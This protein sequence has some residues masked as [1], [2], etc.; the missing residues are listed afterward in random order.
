MSNDSRAKQDSPAQDSN[1]SYSE[2]SHNHTRRVTFTKKQQIIREELIELCNDEINKGMKGIQKSLQGLMMKQND[3]LETVVRSNVT[4]TTI[5]TTPIRMGSSRNPR[6]IPS[7][8]Q[9]STAFASGSQN[10]SNYT[11]FQ[12]S[13]TLTF[14]FEGS[15]YEL[16]D[17]AYSK[18]SSES[19]KVN[20]KT[21]LIYY[22]EEMQSEAITYN[23]FMQPF[24]MLKPWVKYA[25]NT[26]PPTCILSDL[27]LHDN[28]IE[29]YNRMKN[30]L[31]A[32]I[33]KST[34]ND[35][36]YKAIIKHRSIGKDGFEVLYELMTLCHPKLMVATSKVRDT[37]PR[38]SLQ[39]DESIYEY[40][41]RLTTW[42]TIEEINGLEHNDD[43]V[44]NIMMEQMR[45]DTKYNLA[46][47]SI[48]SELTLKDTLFRTTGVAQ[49]PE[50]LKLYH[51]PST[52]LSYYSKDERIQLFP[53]DTSTEAS[54]TAI[55]NQ[56]SMVGPTSTQNETIRDFAQ[57]IVK[58]TSDP[59]TA[60]A[61]VARE[62][63]DEMCE[64][65]GLFGHNIYKSGCD[66]CAQY[67]LIK[68][69]LEKN[70]GND[71]SII[72]KYKKHQKERA[73][74]RKEKNKKFK[75]KKPAKPSQ[76]KRY[77]T[78]YNK[79]KVQ[80]IQDAIMSAVASS[81]SES[82]DDQSYTSAQSSDTQE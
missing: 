19:R 81:E 49:F 33:S 50:H 73:E 32:K 43:Q 45:A 44:L 35:P 17:N 15:T 14:R 8:Q 61:M 53:T 21:D 26:L 22:Y 3:L 42:L 62:G 13:G 38:P 9:S 64:G 41:E 47:Q 78:R 74:E 25:T 54:T 58:V 80:K 37:N 82:S 30:C 70:P 31:Y 20:N 77:N 59:T 68:R 34:F 56:A 48:N 11:P 63:V 57:A 28:T 36:E 55:V 39:H 27:T 7:P 4:G 5:P 69:Y 66:R 23:I 46:V 24:N 52:I 29:A 65:C 60:Q 2:N 12:R 51:L 67:I 75:E 6:N 72:S 76:G 10:S 16:R 40:A 71:K 18:N 1:L 79:A